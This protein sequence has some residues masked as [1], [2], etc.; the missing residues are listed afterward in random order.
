MDAAIR[1]IVGRRIVPFHQQL[2][3]RGRGEQRQ[4]PDA[5]IRIGA[6]ALEQ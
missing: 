2:V 5:L 4:L 1:R 3:A 6:D